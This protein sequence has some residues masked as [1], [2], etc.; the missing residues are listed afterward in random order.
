MVSRYCKHDY[1]TSSFLS[2]IIH[3]RPLCCMNKKTTLLNLTRYIEFFT[4]LYIEWPINWSSTSSLNIT[5]FILLTFY[6][7]KNFGLPVTI[8]IGN[9]KRTQLNYWTLP[10]FKLLIKKCVAIL[11]DN[12]DLKKN[13]YFQWT[14]RQRYLSYYNFQ[15]FLNSR[16]SW[17]CAVTKCDDLCKFIESN[18]KQISYKYLQKR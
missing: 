15:C 2:V 18:S 16:Y 8:S 10:H 9:M 1:T 17:Y 11:L 13:V 14:L 4:E 6:I 3:F 5:L 12:T 7:K